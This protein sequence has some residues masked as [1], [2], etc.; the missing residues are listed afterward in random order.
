MSNKKLIAS[1]IIF[2]IALL[3]CTKST[4]IIY[5]YKEG[6]LVQL[7][8]KEIGQ[9]NR[10]AAGYYYIRISTVLGPKKIVVR[11]FEIESLVQIK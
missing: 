7:T 5:K 9:V 3:G 4:P 11:E 2:L 1:L 8:T 10:I 6:D